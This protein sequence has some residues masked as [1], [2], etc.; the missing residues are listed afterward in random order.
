VPLQQSEIFVKQS[1]KVGAITKLVVRPG[2]GHGWLD[3]MSDLTTF[4]DW[5]DEHLRGIKP[6]QD[7]TPK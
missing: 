6:K 4:G 7:G 3:F 5:F 2:K 1:Q